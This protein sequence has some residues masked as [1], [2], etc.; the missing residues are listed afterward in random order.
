MEFLHTFYRLQSPAELERYAE[1]GGGIAAHICRHAK[2]EA[3]AEG[4]FASL[5]TRQFTDARLR[6]ALLFG[7]LGVTESDLR[8]IPAYTTL[9]AAN[10]RGRA[11]LK[12]WRKAHKDDDT[13]TVV[14]K[15][16][17]TP[18]GRQRELGELADSLFTLC[19][20]HPCGSGELTKR[21]PIIQ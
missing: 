20:P 19:F 2:E 9:L 21:K 14:T 10:S 5:R 8:I 17:D 12:E 7:V 15:P 11:Y 1:W 18:E 16:A 3:T 13:F 4:F 6:R